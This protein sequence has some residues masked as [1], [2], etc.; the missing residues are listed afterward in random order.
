MH[1][2]HL[3]VVGPLLA[4]RDDPAREGQH[5]PSRL[6]GLADGVTEGRRIFANTIKYVLMGTSSNFGNMFSTAGAS[7]VLPFLPMLPSQIL[8][9]NLLYDAGQLTIPTDH[10]DPEQLRA[11]SHWNIAFIRR[12]MLFFG[13][14]SSLFDFLTFAVMIEIFHAGAELFRSGWFVES[15]ATQALVVFA[16]RT[17]RVPF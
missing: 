14:V 9:N 1:L 8:L 7:L 10:V 16:I 15:L 17:R 11:P 4:R 12:S 5:P 13:P 6:G 2:V 3:T